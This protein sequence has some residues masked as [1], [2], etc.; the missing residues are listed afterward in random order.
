ML[1]PF[2]LLFV[3][4]PLMLNGLWMAGRIANRDIV[5]INAS[6]AAITGRVAALLQSYG[7][8]S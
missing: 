3:G 2:S 5:G 1:L 4:A 7:Q 8:K 6:T